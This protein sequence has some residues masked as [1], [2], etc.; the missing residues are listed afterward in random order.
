MIDT[1]GQYK[2]L[3]RV[4]ASA[5]GDL[6][7]GRDL[8]VGR[9]VSIIIV[10]S[11][12][13]ADLAERARFLADATAASRLS[14]PN[15]AAIYEVGVENDRLFLAAEFISGQTLAQLV[16]THPLNP[17]RAIDYAT[18]IADALAAAHGAG[19]AHG[20]V[21]GQTIVVT[22]K[23]SAKILDYGLSAWTGDRSSDDEAGDLAAL[24]RLLFQMLTARVPQR[25]WPAPAPSSV[26]RQVPLELDR[27]VAKLLVGSRQVQTSA[28]VV[29][30]ELRAIGATLDVPEAP[31]D[32]PSMADREA[33]RFSAK[34]L[35]F[36]LAIAG[37][38]LIWAAIATFRG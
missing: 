26:N 24:G 22:A 36:V 30:A 12:I 14:H 21:T 6:Y 2:I 4:G 28:A 13:A 3:E 33:E 5:L 25:G 7:R 8:R 20:A 31:G 29:A 16:G 1:I 18:Q 34:W 27:L 10:A 37:L 15:I 35:V 19:L 9:T 38:A 32:A 17:R 11:E 23:D